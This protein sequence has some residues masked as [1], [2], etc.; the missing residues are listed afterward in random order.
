MRHGK[1]FMPVES[2]KSRYAG[3]IACLIFIM[4]VN[5]PNLIHEPCQYDG[6]ARPFFYVHFFIAAPGDLELDIIIFHHQGTTS[7]GII[8]IIADGMNLFNNPASINAHQAARHHR[9]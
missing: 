4:G 2:V 5:K 9:I 1:Y 7:I 8:H 3:K 6:P